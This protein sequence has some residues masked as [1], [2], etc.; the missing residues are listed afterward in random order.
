M[1][2]IKL[3]PCKRF[4][5]SGFECGIVPND[6]AI[7]YTDSPVLMLVCSVE[8]DKEYL[9]ADVKGYSANGAT[10]T[11]DA[12]LFNGNTASFNGPWDELENF[13]AKPFFGTDGKK[14]NIAITLVNSGWNNEWVC[15]YAMRHGQGVY[16]C[17]ERDYID[18]GETF[19]LFEWI[20][21]KGIGLNQAFYINIQKMKDKM[22]NISK[23]EEG[24][25]QPEWY[26]NFPE[27][28]ESNYYF[29][30]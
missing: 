11:I 18:G 24:N 19:K 7:K 9:F 29:N 5:R 8:V 25:Y 28:L 26:P 6:L 12:R 23:W 3:I 14:Y 2:N 10:W 17:D 16:V 27:N 15:A 21:L 1:G 20:I 30:L 4:I 13:I 22:L